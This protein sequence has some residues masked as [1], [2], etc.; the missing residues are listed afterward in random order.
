MFAQLDT[1]N[2]RL[3][4]NEALHINN[5][6]RP[7]I[8]YRRDGAL[9]AATSNGLFE[10]VDRGCSWQPVAPFGTSFVAALAQFPDDADHLIVATF[11]QNESAL[12]VTRDG[13]RSFALLA[14]LEAR[15]YTQS[16]LIAPHD[17]RLVYASGT[18]LVAGPPPRTVQYVARSEDGGAHWERSEL[19]LQMGELNVQLLA[20]NPMDGKELLARVS[21]ASPGI[22]AERVLWSRD[23]G[24]TFE[25]VLMLPAITG[26][27]FA[28]DG[29]AAWVSASTGLYRAS[30]ARDTFT[31]S[32]DADRLTCV[33]AHESE[34]WTCGHFAGPSSLRDGVG[35]ARDLTGA[36]FESALEFNEIAQPISCPDDSPTASKCR[37]PWLDFNTEV[38]RFAASDAGAPDAADAG[39]DAGNAPGEPGADDGGEESEAAPAASD[40]GNANG[41][42]AHGCGVK[43]PDA[44]ASPFEIALLLV[45]VCAG[46]RSK[47]ARPRAS[48][49]RRFSARDLSSAPPR[50]ADR[51]RS[52]RR[53]A[54]SP[55]ASP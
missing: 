5:E 51:A 22:D 44:G 33:E 29:S 18:R 21:S 50:S 2:F 7:G 40:A 46:R 11:A 25:S 36:A 47:R 8:A 32:G 52:V 43:A 30:A 37:T 16:L 42:Q 54:E 1:R 38:T 41:K 14:Q 15:D 31:R 55:A 53:S 45:V 20:I 10:S 9:L 34:L 35:R 48:E 23:G 12:H 6:E 26:A 27:S 39:G 3:M 13:G 4:C 24:K 19:V 28:A 17:P 49:P